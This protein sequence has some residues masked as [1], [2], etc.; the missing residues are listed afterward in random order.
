MSYP[1][2][3]YEILFQY[4]CNYIFKLISKYSYFLV[5][6]I[7]ALFFYLETNLRFFRWSKSIYE[8]LKNGLPAILGD[9]THILENI[10]TKLGID[11]TDSVFGLII[12]GMLYGFTDADIAKLPTDFE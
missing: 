12:P 11:L 4:F 2:S 10:K 5:F 8:L 7:T 6:L 9:K 1:V 3:I